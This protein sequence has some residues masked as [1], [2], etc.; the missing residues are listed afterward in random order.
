M[1][2]VIGSDMVKFWCLCV[3]DGVVVMVLVGGW[4]SPFYDWSTHLVGGRLLGGNNRR[5]M[6]RHGGLVGR[7]LLSVG[8]GKGKFAPIRHGPRNFR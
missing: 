6:Q 7:S 4:N 8:V 2:V 5:R 3:R 1:G